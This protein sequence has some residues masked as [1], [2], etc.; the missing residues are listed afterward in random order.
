MYEIINDIPTE[1][2]KLRTKKDKLVK[3]PKELQEPKIKIKKREPFI[4]NVNKGGYII[5]EY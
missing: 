5:F 3:P 1:T 2:T 4:F